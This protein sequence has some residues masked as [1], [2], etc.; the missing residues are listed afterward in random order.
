MKC[1]KLVSCLASLSFLWCLVSCETALHVLQKPSS[2]QLIDCH[3]EGCQA[4]IADIKEIAEAAALKSPSKFEVP[5]MTAFGLSSK[6]RPSGVVV[7]LY[8]KL[9]LHNFFL[10]SELQFNLRKLRYLAGSAAIPLESQSEYSLMDP[11]KHE[12]HFDDAAIRLG[13]ISVDGLSSAEFQ[14]ELD[15]FKSRWGEDIL[16]LG[17]QIPEG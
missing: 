8:C 3:S 7:A 1:L 14:S 13:E 16:V 9:S 2:V 17:L 10:I 15:Q 12:L 11:T 4:S 5:W 6:T